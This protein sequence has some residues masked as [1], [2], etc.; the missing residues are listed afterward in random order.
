MN[1]PQHIELTE[2]I[3]IDK[4]KYIINNPTEFNL[5]SYYFNG[6]KIDC[7]NNHLTLLK[8]YLTK[9]DKKGNVKIVYKQ[10]NKTGRY[11][12]KSYSSQAMKK[13]LRHTLLIDNAFDI[14]IKNCHPVLLEWF[15]KKHSINCSSLSYYNDNRAEICLR[16]EYDMKNAVLKFLNGG[17]IEKC[18]DPDILNLCNNILQIH[19]KI[20]EIYSK[21]YLKLVKKETFN[22]TG[23]LISKIL[24]DL[25]NDCLLSMYFYCKAHNIPIYSLVFDGMMI[26]RN[27]NTNN[28]LPSILKGCEEAIFNNTGINVEVVMK[29][30]T[31]GY[32]IKVEPSIPIQT[33]KKIYKLT[34]SQFDNSYFLYDFQD[35]L[36]TT[37]FESE[38]HF[39]NFIMKKLSKVIICIQKP[40]CFIVNNTSLDPFCIMKSL[41]VLPYKHYGIDKDGDE[42]IVKGNFSGMF[43]KIDIY[44]IIPFYTN[45]TY[46][47]TFKPVSKGIYNSFNGF[48]ADLVEEI[49]M[50]K[51]NPILYHIKNV[52]CN[53]NEDVYDYLLTWFH[54]CFKHP[55]KRTQVAIIL[56]GK[57][58]SGKGSILDNFIIPFVYGINNSTSVAGLNN[59]LQRFNGVLMNKLFININEAT[60]DNFVKNCEILKSLITDPILQIEPK[61]LEILEMPNYINF[62]MTTNRDN[63]VYIEKGDRRYLCLDTSDKYTERDDDGNLSIECVNYFNDLYNC[64]NQDVANHFYSY[65]KRLKTSRNIR[66]IP[67][68]QL[69]RDMISNSTPLPLRYL[70]DI[71]NKDWDV[72]KAEDEKTT[73]IQSLDLYEDFKEWC[74][75][76]GEKKV[77]S[78]KIFSKIIK[79]NIEKRRV[80]KGIVYDIST[81]SL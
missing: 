59:I 5:G 62:I 24:L 30:M 31:M 3:D 17:E 23:K 67:M 1:N 19:E 46:I 52:L 9:C 63:A 68:T 61:G 51:I 71:L 65:I 53:Q 11:W 44:F 43:K 66:N 8:E 77:F 70:Q 48:K 13:Q 47:P 74:R 25:E 56:Y 69:K 73:L 57:M 32:N 16:F 60:S 78:H 41:P 29:P 2:R 4:L 58:G 39:H 18:N 7:P 34:H 54:H 14:D 81:I 22:P 49:D 40:E 76:K 35:E 28:N 64:F 79:D 75:V 36:K 26:E 45:I 37:L 27:E 38:I 15:C 6:N 21:E 72:I 50:N 42:V 80:S 20:K 12:A 55:E 33:E 10:H